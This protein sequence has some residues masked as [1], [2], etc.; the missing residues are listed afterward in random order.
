MRIV[1]TGISGLAKEDILAKI[2]RV[3]KK[4]GMNRQTVDPDVKLDHTGDID[5]AFDLEHEMCQCE[6][7]KTP[8]YLDIPEN[9]LLGAKNRTLEK[10]TIRSKGK[11]NIILAMHVVYY[12][13]S[14]L[15]SVFDWNK[16]REFEPE[17]FVTLTDDVYSIKNR[18]GI[19]PNAGSVRFISLKD[20]L[21][22]RETEYLL[23]R[24]IARNISDHSIPHYLV[25][26]SQAPTII[27]Q[28]MFEPDKKKV[29]A[30]YPVTTAKSDSKLRHETSDFLKKLKRHF[31]V[32]DP[33]AIKEKLLHDA[34]IENLRSPHPEPY[35]QITGKN[36]DSQYELID[37]L[38]IISDINGQIVSRDR[39]LVM[40]SDMVIGY[41][42]TE[43]PGAQHELQYARDTGRVETFV[44]NPPGDSQ[45]P[46]VAELADQIFPDTEKLLNR[47][48]EKGYI[49]KRT[50]KL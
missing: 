43:S 28:L 17:L 47:L 45:S 32:F 8:N 12:R 14:S 20:I 9:E 10:L 16:L 30:S 6:K 26:L 38:P 39:R 42:P 7:F 29:Y 18:I 48:R 31:V 34:L 44:V 41:R 49:K 27:F 24:E 21:W 33:M 36:K 5:L 40:Q 22:W 25:A 50:Q 1:L 23:T 13:R 46:F 4:D 19:N 35:I 11:K 15:F 3:G 37:I 2:K